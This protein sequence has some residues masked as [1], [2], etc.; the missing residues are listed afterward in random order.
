MKKAFILLGITLALSACGSKSSSNTTSVGGAGNTP[1]KTNLDT[2]ND[3]T[4][5]PAHTDSTGKKM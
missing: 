2:T 4:H 5:T 1:A 3:S